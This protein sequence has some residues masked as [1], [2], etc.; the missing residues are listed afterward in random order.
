MSDHSVTVGVLNTV[1]FIST[2]VSVNYWRIFIQGCRSCLFQ[3][4]SHCGPHIFT[5]L[6]GYGFDSASTPLVLWCDLHDWAFQWWILAC[7]YWSS[8]KLGMPLCCVPRLSPFIAVVITVEK[9]NV[10]PSLDRYFVWQ[11]DL[12]LQACVV[13]GGRLVSWV[14]HTAE[15]WIWCGWSIRLSSWRDPPS[16]G[17]QW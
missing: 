1:L 8:L 6:E 12:L 16:M 11:A 7:L 17:C 13:I 2:P 3:Y 4:W 5:L 15:V 14:F 10:C 9:G